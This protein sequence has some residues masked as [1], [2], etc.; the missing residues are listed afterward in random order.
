MV[1][2]IV[3][4]GPAD[5]LWRTAFTTGAV[6]GVSK[7]QAG[8]NRRAIIDAATRLFR[9][10]GVDGVGLAELMK[11]AG[12]TQ[13]GFYN[14]FKS[15]ADLVDAVVATAVEDGA[16]QLA[17]AL[18]QPLTGDEGVLDRQVNYYLSEAHRDDIDGGCP[19]AGLAADVARLDPGAQSHFAEGLDRTFDRLAA[20]IA[21]T[22]PGG[23][24]R[25]RAIALY[26]EMVGA[27]VMSRSVAGADRALA[28]EILGQTRRHLLPTVTAK[29]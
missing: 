28:D 21:A 11:A 24:S 15:K 20:L 12:F 6:M 17:Q 1:I 9:E 7:R 5:Y 27:L 16:G 23:P 10:R 4:C 14:H 13:G 26:A 29:A 3:F 25:T 2:D 8:E 18:A 19:V 22:Q